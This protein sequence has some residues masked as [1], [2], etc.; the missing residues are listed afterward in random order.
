MKNVVITIFVI[1]ALIIT[2]CAT[3]SKTKKGAMVGA[4]IG[5]AV[6]AGVGYAVGGKKGAAIGA[7]S[8][9]VVGG[10]TGAAVGRYMDKQEQEMR[11]ALADSEAASIQREQ[12]ILA[13]TFKA[14]VMFNFDSAVIKPGAYS[15]I[16]R[17]AGI[18]NKYPR[19]RIRIEGH[20]DNKGTETYNQSLS[21]RR[22]ENVKNA[23][24]VRTVDPARLETIGLGE[25]QPIAGNETAAGR[26]MN[27]RV[28]IVVIPVS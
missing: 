17:V 10:M 25:T 19:T 28:R 23:L 12:D 5:T 20:T 2:G 6:G 13:V 14:D 3:N 22:A 4:A 7:G 18:L 27:R 16:D 8:G 1:M 26:Q 9:M 15:E 21:E 24:V 11:Q